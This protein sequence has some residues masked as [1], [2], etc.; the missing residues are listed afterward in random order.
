MMQNKFHV[1]VARSIVA[2]VRRAKR[3]RH[4]NDHAR[5]ALISR[6]SRLRRS[7]FSRACTPLTKD[8]ERKMLLAVFVTT[9]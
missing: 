5:A 1:F 4:E 9:V 8:E 7:T 3:W 6:V 2:L